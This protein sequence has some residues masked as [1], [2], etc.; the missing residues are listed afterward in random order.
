MPISR[1]VF[2]FHFPLNMRILEA[3]GTAIRERAGGLW[4]GAGC[5]PRQ[6]GSAAGP[7]HCASS[8]PRDADGMNDSTGTD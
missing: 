7:P 4:A 8:A 5:T 6:G 1:T 2:I 3:R